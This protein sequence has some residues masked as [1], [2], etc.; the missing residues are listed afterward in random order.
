VGVVTLAMALMLVGASARTYFVADAIVAIPYLYLIAPLTLLSAWL[1][2][3]DKDKVRR[4]A[5][6][7]RRGS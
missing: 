3:R 6:P 7:F 1:L 4:L 5:V 2:L